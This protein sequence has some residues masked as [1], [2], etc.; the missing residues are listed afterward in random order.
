VIDAWTAFKP[1]ECPYP[2]LAV[3]PTALTPH[4]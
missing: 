1:Q 4:E 2:G 3:H